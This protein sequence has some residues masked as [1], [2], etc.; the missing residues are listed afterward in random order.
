MGTSVSRTLA[1]DFDKG[2]DTA[3]VAHRDLTIRP[4]ELQFYHKHNLVVS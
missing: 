4:S 1:E 3:E 2:A